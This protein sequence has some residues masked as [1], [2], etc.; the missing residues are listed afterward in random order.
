MK[1]PR[2]RRKVAIVATVV[3]IAGAGALAFSEKARHLYTALERSGR[4]G[5]TLALCVNE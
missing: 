4:V 2:E 5:V 1:S 3:F